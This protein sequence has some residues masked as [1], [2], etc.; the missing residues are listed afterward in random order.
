MYFNCNLGDLWLVKQSKIQ[1]SRLY[2][3]L[4]KVTLY[5]IYL[6]PLTTIWNHTNIN[7]IICTILIILSSL[8]VFFKLKRLIILLHNFLYFLFGRRIRSKHCW[9]TNFFHRRTIK[10]RQRQILFLFQLQLIS[11]NF[12][13]SYLGSSLINDIF[14]LF[15]YFLLIV[16]LQYSQELLS[17]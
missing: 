16:I 17:F 8:K 11:F 12:I 5:D 3:S 9:L 10:L 2:L 4:N 14:L 6:W 15:S 13:Y 1:E 7:K